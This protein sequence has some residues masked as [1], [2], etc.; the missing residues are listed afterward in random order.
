MEIGVGLE[1]E[2]ISILLMVKDSVLDDV[3]LDVVIED[4]V[5]STLELYTLVK[6]REVVSNATAD[7]GIDLL[8]TKVETSDDDILRSGVVVDP[9]GLALKGLLVIVPGIGLT[10]ITWFKFV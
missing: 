7:E 3:R 10:L 1:E 6:S 2:S 9:G 4:D 8:N 5:A